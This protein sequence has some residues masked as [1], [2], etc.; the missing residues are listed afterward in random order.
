MIRTGHRRTFAPQIPSH[1]ILPPLLHY[2]KGKASDLDL[3]SSPHPS[4][5]IFCFEPANISAEMRSID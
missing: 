3:V 1:L 5:A 2:C 4:C